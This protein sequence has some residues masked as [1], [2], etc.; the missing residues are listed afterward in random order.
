MRKTR[1]EIANA[2][3]K[4]NMDKLVAK[5]KERRKTLYGKSINV[6]G[7]IKYR[8]KHNKSYKDVKL[9]VKRI[10]IYNLLASYGGVCPVC[11]EVGG[12]PSIDRK[13]SDGHYIL[14]NLRVIC[15][16]CNQ[17]GARITHGPDGKFM[18]TKTT[19]SSP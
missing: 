8:L 14:E 10:D 18:S 16:G 19:K 1:K 15:L 17:K 6:F 5:N 2:Y 11:A 9:F 3:T 7:G 4:R 12:R 13:D